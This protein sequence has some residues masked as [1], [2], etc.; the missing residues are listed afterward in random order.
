MSAED[1]KHAAGGQS[2]TP[3][4]VECPACGSRWAP[5]VDER[6]VL[7]RLVATHRCARCG[8]RFRVR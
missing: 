7:G 4:R 2:E 8:R 1:K 5:K 3:P 6:E